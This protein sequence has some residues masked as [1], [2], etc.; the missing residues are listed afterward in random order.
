LSKYWKVISF[1]A[2]AD[3]LHVHVAVA[4]V[5]EPSKQLGCLQ[6][7]TLQIVYNYKLLV[8]YRTQTPIMLNGYATNWNSTS[9]EEIYPQQSKF[10]VNFD[11]E[12]SWCQQE[13]V[14]INDHISF[15]INVKFIWDN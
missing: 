4:S 1:I 5:G 12:I 10:S 8:F 11:K 15:Y 7:Y 6:F 14:T 2:T 9:W 13:G 3:T